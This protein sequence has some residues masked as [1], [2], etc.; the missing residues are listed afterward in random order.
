[1]SAQLRGRPVTECNQRLKLF[2]FAESG[3]GKSYFCTQFPKAY[4]IDCEGRIKRQLYVD[5][6]NK[7]D[8][9]VWQTD[10][11]D[12][13]LVEVKTLASVKHNYQTLVIDSI[14]PIYTKL[15]DDC[16]A[17]LLKLGRK[18]RFSEEYQEANK[19]FKKLTDL[20]RVLDMNVIVTA[21]SKD[22]WEDDK[23]NGTTFDAYKKFD[24][25]FE[26]VMEAKLEK[27][28]KKDMTYYKAIIKKST[29]VSLQPNHKINFS[30]EGFK[31]L[32]DKELQSFT[33]VPAIEAEEMP[34]KSAAKVHPM[35]KPDQVVKQKMKEET[36]NHLM[37]LMGELQLSNEVKAQWFNKLKVSSIE[38]LSEAKVQHEIQKIEE[39][40]PEAAKAWIEI[41]SI[42]NEVGEQI[43]FRNK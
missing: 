23:A 26:V 34:L 40:Y 20:L 18:L 6:L 24:Y 9:V 33:P 16:H 15:L 25:Y 19:R 36:K 39:K 5:H 30:Y 7:N 21:H 38:E 12:D 2:L 8:S 35:P 17:N 43:V 1:M 31:R 14:T 13:L 27:D 32:Y 41:A 37:F 29:I 28:P 4:Y 11:F 10:K 22:K 42:R 3:C